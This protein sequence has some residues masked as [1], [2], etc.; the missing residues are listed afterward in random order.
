M[1]AWD[2][3]RVFLAIARGGSL[4]A[5]ARTL[6]VNHSTVF[7]RLNAFETAVGARLFDRRPEG[8]GVT[9]EGAEMLVRATR[10]EEEVLALDRELS[11]RDSRLEGTVRVT[12]TDTVALGL[13]PPHLARFRQAQP[14]IEIELAVS[15]QMYNLSRR[16]AD[17]AIRPAKAPEGAMVGRRLAGIAL[18]AYGARSYLDGAKTPR[19]FEDLADHALVGPDESLSNTAAARWLRAHA[20]G[21]AIGCRC[22]SFMAQFHA[23]RAGVGLGLL[24]CFLADPEPALVRLPLPAPE[25]E[26]GLWLLT[27]E[28]LRR[29]ARIRAVLDFLAEALGAERDLLEGRSAA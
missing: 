25:L 16:E 7:R 12:T 29:T 5:A 2:D 10:I 11:G 19:V 17:V 18:A 4:A 26:T 24:P 22:D 3:L 23:V 21:A 15:N 6:G 1:F 8:Y 20:P 9:A 28:D 14:G 13:L 27:H